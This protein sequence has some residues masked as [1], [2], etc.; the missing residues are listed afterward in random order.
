MPNALGMSLDANEGDRIM[1][2][3]FATLAGLILAGTIAAAQSVTYDFDKTVNFA[4]FKTYAWV[5]G[6]PVSDELNHA[7]IINAVSAQLASK[8]L[9][10]VATTANPDLLIAYHATFDRDLQINGFSS[11]WGGYRFGGWRSGSARTEEILT[12]TLVVDIVAA[13]TKTIVW[14]GIATKD[15]NP[16]ES[17]EK[18]ERN[19]NRAAE[20]LFKNYPPAQTRSSR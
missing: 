8:V 6:T 5:R 9:T 10:R 17:G 18:R 16:K 14:R 2:P 12:G 15:I 11:G 13:N 7:R 1:R 4:A 19:I 20:K 3:L